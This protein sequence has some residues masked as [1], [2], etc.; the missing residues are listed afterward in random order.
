MTGNQQSVLVVDDHSAFRASVRRLLES[1]GYRV[2]AEA[3]DGLSAVAAA[4]RLTPDI[5]V[6]D[7][8]LPDIDGFE[9]AERI[10]AAAHGAPPAIVLVSS[11]DR[12]DFGPLLDSPSVRGFVSKADLTGRALT[13]LL[14]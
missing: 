8:Q 11:R 3:D 13:E 5:V 4:N 6:L 14:R 2:I 1:E 10:A 9:V 7:V 12:S